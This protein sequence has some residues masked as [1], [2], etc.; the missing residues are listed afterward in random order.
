MEEKKKGGLKPLILT[1]SS[2][3]FLG[4]GSLWLVVGLIVGIIY[5]FDTQ[6]IK[7]VFWIL[8]GSLFLIGLTVLL[9]FRPKPVKENK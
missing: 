8:A 7:P 3:L 1:A 6:V 9:V 2:C 5:H 4:S